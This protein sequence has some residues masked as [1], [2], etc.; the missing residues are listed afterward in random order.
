MI[1]KYLGDVFDAPDTFAHGFCGFIT[2]NGININKKSIEILNL[3]K[4]GNW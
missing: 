1:E 2:E 4:L 3:G